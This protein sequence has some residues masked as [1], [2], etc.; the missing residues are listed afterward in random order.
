MLD[1]IERWEIDAEKAFD[2]MSLGNG[3]LKCYCG[4]EFDP[5]TEGG[6]VS[7]NPYSMLVCGNCFK[8]YLNNLGV[9]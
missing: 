8:E 1:Q 5:N 2:E 4:N 9:G 7:S 6:T 3:L